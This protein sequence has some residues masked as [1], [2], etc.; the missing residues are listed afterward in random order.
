MAH[1]LEPYSRLL[2]LSGPGTLDGGDVLRLGRR[3]Y[4]GLSSRSTEAGIRELA[5]LV[6]PHG[7]LVR[8]TAVSGCLHLKSAVTAIGN[9]TVLLNP[10]WVHPAVFDGADVVE[11]DL[12]EPAGANALRIGDAVI[13]SSAF[14]RTGERLRRAGI[15][16]REVDASELA[17]AEGGVTCCSV[18]LET[19]PEGP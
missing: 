18:I 4:V 7:Y 5:E 2:R 11:V 16:L 14:P 1:A 12:G 15:R 10:A 17:K 6:E 8:G 13:Y 3:L 9:G 19:P